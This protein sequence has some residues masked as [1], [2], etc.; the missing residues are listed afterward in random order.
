M[1]YSS[2][3][4]K[5]AKPSFLF[6]PGLH[7]WEWETGVWSLLLLAQPWFGDWPGVQQRSGG[8]TDSLL[9]HLFLAYS[10]SIF[11]FWTWLRIPW[12]PL[13]GWT[14]AQE[15]P[16]STTGSRCG[17]DA[18]TYGER[19]RRVSWAVVCRS[20]KR[21]G[22]RPSA[23]GCQ[24]LS[25]LGLDIIHH[26]KL[27]AFTEKPKSTV[28]HF[29]SSDLP[30]FL[31][32]LSESAPWPPLHIITTFWAFVWSLGIGIMLQWIN[33]LL[34]RSFIWCI[35]LS[36]FRSWLYHFLGVWCWASYLITWSLSFLICKVE[37]ILQGCSDNE[38]N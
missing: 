7:V 8:E 21:W 35:S 20:W 6:P 31:I 16:S 28:V 5:G 25:R 33:N 17:R 1:K 24:A 22:H 13:G 23:L 32:W 9:H 19:W 18:S 12:R 11:L 15:L 38:M 27:A 29:I 37:P 26:N 30:C 3:P 4:D 34:F 36:G 10:G 2:F 14:M